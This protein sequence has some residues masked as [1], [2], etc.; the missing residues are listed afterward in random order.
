MYPTLGALEAEGLVVTAGDTGRSVYSLTDA[1]RAAAADL[2]DVSPPWE[3]DH[4]SI[5]ELAH[6]VEALVAAARQVAEVGDAAQQAAAVTAM[7]DARR[8]LYAI[9]ATD[10]GSSDQAA[11]G[12]PDQ[13]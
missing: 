8:R 6:A 9:L 13:P 3:R 4:E 11:A 12:L 5:H 2:A 1:G 7:V 10:A